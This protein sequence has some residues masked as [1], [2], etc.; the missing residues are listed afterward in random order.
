MWKHDIRLLLESRQEFEIKMMEN[1][2]QIFTILIS[3]LPDR[4]AEYL[5]IKNEVGV[6]ALDEKKLALQEH[7]MNIVENSSKSKSGR[8]IGKVANQP[9]ER[10]DEDEDWPQ[11]WDAQ[12]GG[13]WI[14][15]PMKRPSVE[16]REFEK[17]RMQEE[18]DT[19]EVREGNAE[20]G[21]AG[22]KGKEPKGKGKGHKGG[23]HDC[24]GDH[25]VRDCPVRQERKGNGKG[26]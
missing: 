22:G 9:G 2:D 25:Y 16:E 21:K 19:R 12:G 26:W 24:G 7:M 1:S 23:C 17:N 18:E 14:R 8:E 4:V 20:A 15:T 6:T 3:M 11:N 13:Y 5:M 10:G